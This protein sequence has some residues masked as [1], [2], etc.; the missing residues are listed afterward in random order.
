MLKQL[1]VILFV[2][3]VYWGILA[4]SPT[5]R[6][7]WLMENLLLIAVVIL[8]VCTFRRFQFSMLSYWLIFVF[9][10]FHAYGAHYTYQGTPFDVWLKGALHTH[11]SYYDRVVHFLFGLLW[12][13]PAREWLTRVTAVRRGIWSYVLPVAIVFG[14]SALFEIIEMGAALVAGQAGEE[15][16]GMQGDPFDSEKD[17]GLGLAGAVTSM[18]MLD[19]KQRL[20]SK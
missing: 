3:A 10:C 12:T 6:M 4:I 16:V 20:E 14:F 5:D 17:M 8:L 7:Q 18:C 2:F 11:R 13:Y 19:W 1:Q 15:Y 9:L